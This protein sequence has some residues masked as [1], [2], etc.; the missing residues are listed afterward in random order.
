ME[1]LATSMIWNHLQSHLNRWLFPARIGVSVS[2]LTP[3][4]IKGNMECVQS[5][6]GNT[7]QKMLRDVMPVCKKGDEGQIQVQQ[8][9]EVG[10]ARPRRFHSSCKRRT[11]DLI[12]GPRFHRRY[13]W[14]KSNSSCFPAALDTEKAEPF[15]SP[16]SHLLNDLSIQ[17]TLSELQG[18]VNTNTPFDINKLEL[19]LRSH[20]NQLFGRS[21]MR[22]LREGFWPFDEG[23]WDEFSEDMEN[24]STDELDLSAIRDF[25]NKECGAQ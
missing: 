6:E 2:V 15:P 20:P 9:E 4:L 11:E 5:V 17:S 24:Y 19:F 10:V 7:E 3:V 25:K 18:Y 22:S 1:R 13:V 8:Q 12:L 23:E 14:S 16:P 21:I